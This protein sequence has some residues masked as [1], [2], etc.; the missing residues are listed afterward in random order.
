MFCQSC[1]EKIDDGVLFCQKCGAKIGVNVQAE[2]PA[3]AGSSVPFNTVAQP[4]V[5]Q[6]N[7]VDK[8][9]PT[10]ALVSIIFQTIGPVFTFLINIFK[11]DGFYDKTGLIWNITETVGFICGIILLVKI[12]NIIGEA[13]SYMIIIMLVIKSVVDIYFLFQ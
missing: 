1:G 4:I 11:I 9:L 8:N 6:N 5:P 7:L 10:L 12:K 2:Q 13:I 3:N